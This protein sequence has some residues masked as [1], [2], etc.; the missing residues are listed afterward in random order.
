MLTDYFIFLTPIHNYIYYIHYIPT[1]EGTQDFG[2]IESI[3]QSIIRL[4]TPYH[5]DLLLRLRTDFRNESCG[6]GGDDSDEWWSDEGD[7][8]V[9]TGKIIDFIIYLFSFLMKKKKWTCIEQKIKDANFDEMP[10]I[11]NFYDNA[12]PPHY[13]GVLR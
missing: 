8:N 3:C 4:C 6:L 1:R 13:S 2:S 11:Y 5:D 9:D 7:D 12:P 10:T